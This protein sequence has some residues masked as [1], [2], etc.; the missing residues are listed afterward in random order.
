[1]NLPP[2]LRGE[3]GA[4]R[5]RA[6]R[7]AGLALAGA[8]VLGVLLL[9]YGE[10]QPRPSAVASALPVAPDPERVQTPVADTKVVPDETSGLGAVVERLVDSPAQVQADASTAIAPAVPVAGVLLPLA[11]VQPGGEGIYLQ[12]GVF[13]DV[14]NALAV[15]ERLAEAGMEARI[16]SRVVV[17][18]FADRRAAERAQAALRKAG[19]PEG[20][21]VPPRSR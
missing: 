12:L 8:V 16:Q 15:Y 20:I 19:E 10:R 6:L 17:G 4:L 3:A 21:L 7:R 9:A 1:M 5:R 2:G 13:G 18:P 11:A 14:S